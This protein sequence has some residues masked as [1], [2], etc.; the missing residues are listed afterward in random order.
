[1]TESAA[2][3]QEHHG[4]DLVV[5][6]ASAGG[7]EALKEIVAGLPQDLPAAICI[8]LHIAPTTT[9]ALAGIL[10]RAGRLPCRP[11]LNGDPL[12]PGTILVAPPDHHLL[13]DDG[14]V[15]LDIGPR[16]NGHRPAVDTLFR[17]AAQ[18]R[19]SGVV[20][21]VLSGTRDD[22][23]A[24]LAVIKAHAG[25]TIVQDPADALYGGMPASA[26]AHVEVD[27]VAPA[28]L[29]A[30]TIDAM[31][32]GT[33]LPDGVRGSAPTN[34]PMAFEQQLTLV[35]PECGGVLSETEEQ[36]V[37]RWRCHIG[38]VYSARTLEEVQGATVERALW[39]ALRS[40]EDR[41]A[42]LRK[43]SERASNSGQ[44]RSGRSF[45][46]Q[47]AQAQQQADLVR[48]VI[49]EAAA[50]A[51]RSQDDEPDAPMTAGEAA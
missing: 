10:A 5:I 35:C 34:D 2:P 33:T 43:M 48:S 37:T 46:D 30:A 14:R 36:G 12:E 6:G 18:E 19:A 4:R 3:Q 13:I 25:G 45:A 40:L 32:R 1:V 16:E 28:S 39:T 8:V 20:G 51:Q 23:A 42:L 7:V 41:A 44:P 22:G 27:A 29:I 15:L 50:G 9:S 24:G 17:S 11:A 21:V 26:L 38:H 47:A 31:V 49:R